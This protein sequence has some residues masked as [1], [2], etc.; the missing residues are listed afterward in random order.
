MRADITPLRE[1]HFPELRGVLDA[2]AREGRYLAFLQA[3]S[4]DQAYAFY[5]GIL[6]RDCPHFVALANELMEGTHRQAFRVNGE[7]FDAFA[8]GRPG[9]SS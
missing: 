1:E 3:P 2:V 4:V 8:M 5:R 9:S 7:Y 6:E